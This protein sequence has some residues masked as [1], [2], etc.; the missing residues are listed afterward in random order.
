MDVTP[1]MLERFVA[2]FNRTKGWR[3]LRLVLEEYS[4]DDR[5]VKTCLK[6]AMDRGDIEGERLANILL[7]LP[8]SMR[9]KVANEVEESCLLN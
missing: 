9:R 7:M 1:T 2:Y 6:I 5:T 3:N 8:R 4:T